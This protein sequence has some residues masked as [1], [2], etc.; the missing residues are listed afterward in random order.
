[1][2]ARVVSSDCHVGI[3]TYGLDRPASGIGRYVI[4]LI[5]ALRAHQPDI[6]VTLLQPFASALMRSASIFLL[7]PFGGAVCFQE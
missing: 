3:L 6:A 5:R 2:V 1:V 7:L 4:E